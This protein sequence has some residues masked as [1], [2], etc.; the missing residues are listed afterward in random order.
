MS[1]SQLQS[2]RAQN[3]MGAVFFLHWP[4]SLAFAL[5]VQRTIAIRGREEGL[6]LIDALRTDEKMLP[7]KSFYRFYVP[8]NYC[9]L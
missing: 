9:S 6:V 8:I 5:K 2:Q 1:L 4:L 3:N 7:L